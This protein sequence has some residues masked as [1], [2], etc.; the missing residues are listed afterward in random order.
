M[1]D[2]YDL[3]P[4]EPKKP[5][6]D[7]PTPEEV[8][9]LTPAPQ[10]ASPND[11]AQSAAGTTSLPPGFVPPVP[12]IEGPDPDP[13][14]AAKEDAE[15]H[16]GV[17][18]VGYIPPLFIIPL[19]VAPNSKFAKYHANQ[20]LLVFII[21]GACTMAAIILELCILVLFPMLRNIHLDI[22]ASLGSCA[23]HL[24]AMALLVAI[25]GFAIC[26]IINAANGETKPLPLI[27][28]YTL[29]R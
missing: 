4:I 27:G 3:K 14:V 28:R 18:I 12:I 15:K 20:G 26:G 1:T 11:T 9:G 24:G 8:V 7:T 22:L 21:A 19:L 23:A 5:A 2:E 25:A 16:K 6:S 10:P 13:E 29:I 17:A